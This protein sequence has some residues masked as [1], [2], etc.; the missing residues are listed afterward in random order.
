M[1]RP[2]ARPGTARL[3]PRARRRRR[4]RGGAA[5]GHQG[6]VLGRGLRQHRTG[7][8]RRRGRP[9][10][11]RR[12]ADAATRRDGQHARLG[13]AGH[14]DHRKRGGQLR[15]CGRHDGRAGRG[16]SAASRL[17]ARRCRHRRL[18]VRRRRGPGHAPARG[19]RAA[20]RP[21]PAGPP[22]RGR[23]RA[24]RLARAV[25]RG[26]A[27]HRCGPTHRLDGARAA[28]ARGRRAGCR[29][30]AARGP[31]RA[32]RR[33]PVP[34]PLVRADG[35]RPARVRAPES[36]RARPGRARRGTG[37]GSGDWRL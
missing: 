23:R 17:L 12:R 29:G 33:A 21:A 13:G 18:L 37:E 30:G 32:R 19:G 26:R 16:V 11:A 15:R 36:R 8:L 6:L 2:R 4:R 5:H 9:R 7:D 28:H 20:R 27:G 10:P 31:A 25:A 3:A 14:A 24:R 35:G 1:G 22:R 34:R